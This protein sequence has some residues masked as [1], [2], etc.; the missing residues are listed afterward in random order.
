MPIRHDFE[1][2]DTQL[3]GMTAANQQLLGVK[4]A[5][6][7][8]LARWASHWDGT[9]F[10]QATTWSRHVTSSLDQVIGASGRYIEKARLAN[11]DMRAQ[12]VSNTAL[13]A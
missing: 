10:T 13:W 4:E 3:D 2:I 8:E 6:E 5:M 9:A 12:E 1:A 11:A 7:S